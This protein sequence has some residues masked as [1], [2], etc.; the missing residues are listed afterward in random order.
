MSRL[1]YYCRKDIPNRPRSVHHKYS[2][3]GDQLVLVTDDGK[4]DPNLQYSDFGVQAL[5][6]AGAIDL[7]KGNYTLASSE[8]SN[9]DLIS[10][11]DKLD[12]SSESIINPS[13]SVEDN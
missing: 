4:P 11:V 8:F 9:H 6:D 5:L 7:L 10:D 13:S 2:F 12:F 1:N 3:V